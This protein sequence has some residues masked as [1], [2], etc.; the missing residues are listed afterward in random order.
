MNKKN[1][2]WLNEIPI[3]NEISK[4]RELTKNQKQEA[5]EFEDAVKN[6]KIKEWFNK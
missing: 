6:N 3:P 5:K 1:P 2:R 4:K